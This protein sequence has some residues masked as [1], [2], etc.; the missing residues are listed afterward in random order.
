M[1][2]KVEPQDKTVTVNGL[3]LHYLDWGT[4]G[5]TTMVLLHGLRGHSHSWDD[6]SPAMCGDFHV[7]ALDQR[8]RGESDWAPNGEYTTEAYV[9]D[10][11]GFC[12]ALSLEPFVLVGHSMG[13]RNAMAFAAKYPERMQKLIMVDIGPEADPR[14]G[15]RIVREIKAVPEEFDTFEDIV[16]YIGR[17]NRWLSE[18]NLRRRLKY[19][20]RELPNGKIGWRYDLEIRELRRRGVTPPGEDSWG[21]ARNVSCPTLI[22]RGTETDI[23]NPEIAQKMLSTMANATL[24]EVE[25][26]GHMPME[27]NPSDFIAAVRRYLL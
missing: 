2:T 3:K 11:A 19:Q 8:G 22:V 14:G 1:T 18:A 27:E 5:R 17:E 21:V 15:A 16:A 23:L 13:G 10:V 6:F 25:R 9:A 4:A 24:T 12:D 26:A 20:T 7:L